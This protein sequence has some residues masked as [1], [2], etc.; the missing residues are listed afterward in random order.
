MASIEFVAPQLLVDDLSLSIAWY[1][2]ELGF[3][4]EF[5]YEGF[6]AALSR[7]GATLHLKCAPKTLADRRHRS[8]GGHLDA[9]FEVKGVE[10]ERVRSHLL[11][12]YGVGLIATSPTDLRIAF[13]C[14]ELSEI[15]KL[16]ETLHRAIQELR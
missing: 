12:R 15:E 11:D 7:G 10:A 4:T 1:E 13:S 14:L 8:E 9:F 6:Y 2:Q 16:F 5:V 3:R